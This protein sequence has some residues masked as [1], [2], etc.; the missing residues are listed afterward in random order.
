M[1]INSKFVRFDSNYRV[2]SNFLDAGFVRNLFDSIWKFIIRLIRKV[3][4]N[5]KNLIK[6]NS[7]FVRFDSTPPLEK[8]WNYLKIAQCIYFFISSKE[9]IQQKIHWEWKSNYKMLL[10]FPKIKWFSTNAGMEEIL[11]WL[12]VTPLIHPW[13]TLLGNDYMVIFHVCRWNF[14]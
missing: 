1:K 6:I 14:K 10:F 4:N 11:L 2:K 9:A 3:K 5:S 12:L 13:P 7:K 8:T